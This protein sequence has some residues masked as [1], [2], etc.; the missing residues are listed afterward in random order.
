ME[1]A[2]DVLYQNKPVGK[3]Y[4]TLQGLY[5]SLCCRCKLAEGKYTLC[6]VSANCRTDLGMLYPLE[7]FFGLDCRIPAK[8]L[9]QGSV[10]FSVVEKIPKVKPVP[11]EEKVDTC[12]LEK[13]EQYRFVMFDGKPCLILNHEKNG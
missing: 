8:R 13:L 9:G 1:D 3:V 7:G 6:A 10:I 2:Y 11:L 5:I 12:V 4:M